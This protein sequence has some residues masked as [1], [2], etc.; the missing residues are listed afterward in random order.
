[1]DRHLLR[2]IAEELAKLNGAADPGAHV[3]ARLAQLTAPAGKSFVRRVEMVGD[4][5]RVIEVEEGKP[6]KDMGPVRAVVAR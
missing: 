3:D 5:A 6:A 2:V 4:E 1:M